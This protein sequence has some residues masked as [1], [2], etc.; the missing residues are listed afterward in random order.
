MSEINSIELLRMSLNISEFK[1]EKSLQNIALMNKG[2]HISADFSKFVSNAK[3]L[4]GEHQRL[5]AKTISDNWRNVAKNQEKV[6]NGQ[7]EMDY[8]L[9][10]SMKSS[11]EFKKYAEILNRRI[12][13]LKLATSGG[14]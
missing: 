6:T 8:E 14:K 3:S 5:F 7:V 10:Q 9:S 12:G 11:D 2:E 4:E 1:A 13:L